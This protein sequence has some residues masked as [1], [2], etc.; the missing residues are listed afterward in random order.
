MFIKLTTD[1]GLVGFGEVGYEGDT[2]AAAHVLDALQD[3][4]LGCDPRAIEQ[5]WA[6]LS[7][8]ASHQG[9]PLLYSVVS[10]IEQASWDIKGKACGLPIYEMLGGPCR[11]R[12]RVYANCGGDTSEA[13]VLQAKT[14]RVRAYTAIKMGMS[15]PRDGR[16]TAEYVSQSAARI[17]A[18]REEMGSSAEIA[19]NFGGHFTSAT[20][21]RLIEAIEPSFPMFVEA[22][23][24]ADNV[25]A[26]VRI[27]AST[28]VP[29]AGGGALLTRWG[30]R[31]L[32]EKQAVAIIQPT[33]ALAGGILE[34]RKIAAMAETYDVS[35]AP[36]S[37]LGPISLAAS[38]QLAAC[39]PNFLVQEHLGMANKWDLGLGLLKQ[40]FSVNDGSIDLPTGPGLGIEI[41]E[42]GLAERL[43]N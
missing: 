41:N 23:C 7:R 3:L 29:I 1:D 6:R 40:P 42:E 27:G 17:A 5:T 25:D 35:V 20:S 33:V 34:T 12:M 16:V 14:F 13:S 37:P 21:L 38:L 39:T 24:P 36:R 28:N 15:P 10:G 22:P 32:L 2:A 26:L 43:L 8:G 18:V 30:F 4:I 11:D 31:E 19:V 9:G